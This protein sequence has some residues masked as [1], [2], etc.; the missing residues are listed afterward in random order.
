MTNSNEQEISLTDELLGLIEN[1]KLDT[2]SDLLS[3][4]HPSEIA[5]ELESVPGRAMETIWLMLDMES[6]GEVLPY[7]QDS[8]R[9]RLLQQIPQDV[10]IEYTK[11]LDADDVTDIIQDLPE[12]QQ[13]D[14]LLSMDEQNRQRL[15]S[16]LFYPEDTAG[17]LMSID[18]ISVRRDLTLATVLRYLRFLGRGGGLP[19]HTNKL[20]VVDRNNYF[21]GT[22]SL[23]KI[24]SSDNELTVEDIMT[25]EEALTA[26][27]PAHDVVTLFEQRDMIS[28]AVIDEDGMLLGRITI[29]DVVDVIQDK[30]ETA[31]R[32]MAGL[33]DDDL[34]APILISARNRTVWLGINLA[35]ALLAS[36]VI[37]RF[38][39]SIQQLVALAVLMPIVAS[40]GGI[41][42]SQT[43]T[44]ATR[45]IALGH[46][47]NTN[48]QLLM[49]KELAVGMINGTVW[50]IVVALISAYWFSDNGLGMVI[51][52]AMIIN[53][54]IAALAGAFI[55]LL[56][57][58]LGIDP[59]IAGGVILTTVTDVVGFMS[60]LGLATMTLL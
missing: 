9:S 43:L 53:L 51:G 2:V 47:S 26:E 10:L 21:I 6:Q 20:M 38:E 55:P 49:N 57:N 52:I 33:G 15:A 32:S 36:L 1:N 19:E 45:G 11:D 14:I 8:L 56:L 12:E 28:A 7:L 59:A 54:F 4:L 58:R 44:I 13:E 34:F 50:A 16:L 17:G 42:G 41:A 30:A 48:A 5:H 35:T 29:D 60:F 25:E 27:T 3:D 18:V 24:V 37:G 31:V 46:I 40:M 22:L 23:Q 39:E